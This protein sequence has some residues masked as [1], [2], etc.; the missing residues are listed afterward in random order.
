ME[1]SFINLIAALSS[2]P[3]FK[4]ALVSNRN[5][6]H[7]SFDLFHRLKIHLNVNEFVSN[8]FIV[9]L[10]D[11]TNVRLVIGKYILHVE[12]HDS[13]IEVFYRVIGT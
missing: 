7:S 2:P 13:T 9:Q 1:I 6:S 10:S 5:L 11:K 12:E 8:S 4:S 3:V